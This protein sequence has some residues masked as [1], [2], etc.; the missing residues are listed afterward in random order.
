M[1]NVTFK[2]FTECL[3]QHLRKLCLLWYIAKQQAA[4]EIWVPKAILHHAAL[5]QYILLLN[6]LSVF[7]SVSLL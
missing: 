2:V 6:L 3:P 1:F 5:S 7:D 4:T